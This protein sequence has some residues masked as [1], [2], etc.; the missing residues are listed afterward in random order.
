MPGSPLTSS[1]WPCPDSGLG[2]Q[3]PGLLQLALAAHHPA[4]LDPFQHR[5]LLGRHGFLVQDVWAVEDAQD[6]GRAAGPCRRV[7]AQQAGDQ[8]IQGGRD[9][10]I[11]GCAAVRPGR[12]GAGK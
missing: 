3:G 10:G 2:P 7:L 8:G 4:T 6:L 1:S 5:Q 11:P 12:A 9:V